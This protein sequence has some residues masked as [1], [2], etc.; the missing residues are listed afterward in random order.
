MEADFWF[1][2]IEAK[3]KNFVDKGDGFYEWKHKMGKKSLT[4]WKKYN[5]IGSDEIWCDLI[6]VFIE[7]NGNKYG[8]ANF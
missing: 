3:Q 5:L 6:R 7:L 4:W 8:K 2:R 1:L